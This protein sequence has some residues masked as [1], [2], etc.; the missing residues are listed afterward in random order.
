MVHSYILNYV[1]YNQA[2]KAIIFPFLRVWFFTEDLCVE[3]SK[4]STPRLREPV[5]EREEAE[6]EEILCWRKDSGQAHSKNT[7]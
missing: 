5:L 2:D 1:A 7:Y 3:V 4:L 6:E